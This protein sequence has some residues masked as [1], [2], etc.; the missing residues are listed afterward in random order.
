MGPVHLILPR[1]I[2]GISFKLTED[3]IEVRISFGSID[4]EVFVRLMT[5]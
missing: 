2:N 4:A 3:A 1:L 5:L